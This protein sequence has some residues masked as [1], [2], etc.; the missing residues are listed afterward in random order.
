MAFE[1]QSKDPRLGDGLTFV[2]EK[3]AATPFKT[4][5]ATQTA[6][7]VEKKEIKTYLQLGVPWAQ[8]ISQVFDYFKSRLRASE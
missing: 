3:A 1:F 4:L 5:M 2:P 6:S 8:T 7:A